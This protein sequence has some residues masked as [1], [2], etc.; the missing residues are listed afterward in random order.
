MIVGPQS[1][2]HLDQVHMSGTPNSARSG[3]EIPVDPERAPD[4][5]GAQGS[6]RFGLRSPGE[7]ALWGERNVNGSWVSNP[8]MYGHAGQELIRVK[9]SISVKRLYPAVFEEYE[10]FEPVRRPAKDDS[11]TIRALAWQGNWASASSCTNSL[12][13]RLLSEETIEDKIYSEDFSLLTNCLSPSSS[14]CVSR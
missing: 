3:I 8:C 1:R 6:T 14:C 13:H 7:E 12:Q 5:I 2:P 11:K 9:A 10:Q 4:T